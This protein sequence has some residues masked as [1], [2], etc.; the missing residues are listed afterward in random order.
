MQLGSAPK[1]GC[2]VCSQRTCAHV[3]R[4]QQLDGV[5]RVAQ[6]VDLSLYAEGGEGTLQQGGRAAHK[7]DRRTTTA[8]SR[9]PVG[10]PGQAAA[11]SA[12]HA[13][14]ARARSTTRRP[15]CTPPVRA[16]W[17]ARQRCGQSSL[18]PHLRQG[19]W[20]AG[21]RGGG[22]ACG[23][24]AA[25]APAAAVGQPCSGCGLESG[26]ATLMS[27]HVHARTHKHTHMHTHT[28]THT[29]AAASGLA[30]RRTLPPPPPPQPP[31]PPPTQQVHPLIEHSGQGA[32]RDRIFSHDVEHKLRGQGQ[33]RKRKGHCS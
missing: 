26:G 22:G 23:G 13:P 4:A 16:G 27:R 30:A 17:G 20:A 8:G 33:P 24:G 18:P 9:A 28:H 19:E 14:A 11:P 2:K 7:R 32:W 21:G 1:A 25:A 3:I 10:S 15:P 5:G 29:H 31:P 12:R 6:A